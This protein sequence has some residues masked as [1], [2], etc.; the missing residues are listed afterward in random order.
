MRKNLFI[1]MS[2]FMAMLFTATLTPM[3]ASAATDDYD[4]VPSEVEDAAP[5]GGDNN[6][7]GTI[8]SEQGEV[9]SITNPNDTAQPD[10]YV[11]L[12]VGTPQTYQAGDFSYNYIDSAWTITNFSTMPA[13]GTQ[14]DGSVFPLGLFDITLFCNLDAA[15]GSCGYYSE[16]CITDSNSDCFIPAPANL[17][18]IFNRV[19]DTSQW[20][21]KKYD[22]ASGQYIDFSDYVTIANEI[23]GYERTTISW[24]L[25]DGYF[26]DQDGEVN[27][28]ISDPI[29]PSVPPTPVVAT[30]VT[31]AT[32][33]AT[34]APT[35]APTGVSTALITLLASLLVVTSV[36]VFGAAALRR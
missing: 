24:T 23:I 27:S 30:P 5:N 21:T 17:K 6:Y 20:T 10:S 33:A 3:T 31:S 11:T 15:I 34:P 25:Y 9:A 2:I 29:G 14:P 35:L 13:Q 8:D 7:D 28:Y 26:G 32:P 16:I 36:G 18:L 19:M 22:P 1:V 12:Q 4:S